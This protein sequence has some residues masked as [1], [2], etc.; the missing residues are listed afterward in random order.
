VVSD[1]I[2]LAGG[3]PAVPYGLRG[4]L[5]ARLTLE[6]A[7]REAHSGLTG[8]VAR[9]PLAE[10]CAVV[11]SCV[12]AASG[13]VKIPGFYKMVRPLGKKDRAQFLRSGFQV[14]TF[15]AAHQLTKLRARDR[16]AVMRRIWAEPTFEVHGF[17]GGYTGPGVKTSIPPRAEAKVSMRLVPDQNP[18]AIFALLRKYVRS[19]NP[20]VRVEPEGMLRPYVGDLGGPY[21]EAAR[22]AMRFG[23]GKEP[24]FIREGGSI[25]AV[26]TMVEHW[27][28]PVMF[29]G[30]SLPDHGYHAPNERFDWGQASGGMRAFVKYFDELSRIAGARSSS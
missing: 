26:V 2:W 12:D 1:T 13:R 17:V 14:K 6:T 25:G 28:A 4:L 3:R 16:A 10:L 19:L 5:A 29:L 21:A 23:F 18:A 15:A 7:T 27:R 11:E 20:D 30:L 8:G 24:A 9:N 22:Q